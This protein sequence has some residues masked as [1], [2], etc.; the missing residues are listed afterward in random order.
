MISS[1]EAY[2]L[3]HRGSLALSQLEHNGIGINESYVEQTMDELDQD[4]QGLRSQMKKTDTAKAWKRQYGQNFNWDSNPQLGV[5][6]FDVMGHD[7]PEGARTTT[8]QAKCDQATLEMV[9]D[10]CVDLL[11]KVRK[12]KKSW[13]MLNGV[14]RETVNGRAHCVYNLHFAVTYRSSCDSFNFQQM[15]V[16]DPEQAEM[17]RRAFVASKGRR[18]VETDFGGI[19][20][21]VAYCYHKD[22]RMFAYLT[23][24]TKDMHRDMAAQSF[25]L[26]PTQIVKP[27]RHIGKNMFVFPQFYGSWYR[28]CARN[29]WGAINRQDDCL[30]KGTD[31]TVLEHLNRKGITELGSCEGDTIPGTFEHHMKK[32]EQDFWRNRFSVYNQW[33]DD[34]F[35]AYQ[36]EGGF[37]TLTGFYLSGTYSKNDVTNYPVQGSAFH[38]LLLCLIEIQR[39]LRKKKMKSRIVGQIHDS[40][41]GDVVDRELD[42]YL[43]ICHDVMT[44]WLL[45]KWKWI[46][47]PLSLIHI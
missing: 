16:R 1:P 5:I 34:W 46:E 21:K 36:R 26:K 12:K 15:P 39:R 42:D 3:F 10:P 9:A 17:V 13:D 27:V 22:P 20:V 14:K 11:L 24:P 43:H 19:E 29:M 32:V 25:K 4:I 18:L 31:R 7:I 40:I 47:V 41:I 33:K 35:D 37:E 8:G 2:D 45:R 28:E 30:L 38:C 44:K 23:D 6:L